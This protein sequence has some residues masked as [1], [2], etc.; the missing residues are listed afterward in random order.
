MH[1]LL[2]LKVYNKISFLHLWRFKENLH[3]AIISEKNIKD[4]EL[5][6]M[7]G[8]GYPNYSTK[9]KKFNLKKNSLF[10]ETL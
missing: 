8:L 9:K 3:I 7:Y 1:L 6:L 4:E 2:Y 5:L 10:F